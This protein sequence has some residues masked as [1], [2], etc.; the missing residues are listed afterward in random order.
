MFSCPKLRLLS[1]LLACILSSG[2]GALAAEIFSDSFDRPD[3]PVDGWTVFRGSWTL[4]DGELALTRPS[5]NEHWIWAGSPAL[6][7][8]ADAT[9]AIYSF[10]IRFLANGTNAQ[11]GRHGGFVFCADRPTQR[12]DAQFKG[13]FVDWID[14]TVDRGLRFTRVDSGQLVEIVRGAPDSPLE[15]PLRWRIEVDDTNI[16]LYGDD[17]LYIDV[18]DATYRGGY[19]GFWTW[20]GGQQIAYDDFT[21]SAEL[22]PLSACFGFSPE[23]PVSGTDMLFDAGCS[24]SEPPGSI[25]AYE[26]DF[27][28]GTTA[29]GAVV[30]HTYAFAD[31]YTVTLTI[32]N[33]AGASDSASRL[34]SV[35]GECLPFADDFERPPGP[36]DGWTAFQGDWNITASGQLSTLTAGQEHWVW[37]G[38]PPCLA[39]GNLTIEFDMEFV[40]RP[41]D[42]VGRHAGVFFFASEPRIRWGISGYDVWWID[43]TQDFGISIRRWD[44]GAFTFLTPGSFAAVPEPPLRWRVEVNGATIRVFGDGIQYVQLNDETYRQ[45]HLGFWAYSNTQDVLFDDLSV[46]SEPPRAVSACFEAPALGQAGATLRFDAS[47]STAPP[48]GEATYSWDFGDGQAGSGQI[49]EHA[50]G[51][52]GAYTVVLT[53]RDGAG[54]SDT[55]QKLVRVAE[56]LLPFA[57]CFDRDPGPAGGWTPFQ[58]DWLISEDERLATVTGGAEHWLWA[59]DPPRILSGDFT[60]EFEMEF[61]SHPGD[62]VGRHAGVF[63]YASAPTIRW[64]VSGYDV[65]WIDRGADFGISVRRWDSG[66]ITFLTPGTF[67]LV[68]EPPALWRVEVE[69]PAIRVYGDGV[70]YVE[71]EDDTYRAGYFG[72][73][74]YSNNQDVRFNDVLIGAA[75]LPSCGVVAAKRFVRGDADSDG[76]INLTDAVRVLNFL[77]TGGAPPACA[78]AADADDSGTLSITDAI[79]ILGWLFSGG[80]APMPPSPSTANYVMADCGGDPTADPLACDMPAAKCR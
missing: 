26:W 56:P 41:G 1:A 4:R 49:V 46:T 54:G 5:P 32:R 7:V 28:D 42:G 15:P 19:F 57:D 70:L 17:V 33:A 53:V 78:D 45:G 14:R 40:S 9:D 66:A 34:V 76:T 38:D 2:G 71:V 12:Y 29:N 59:G 60:L 58:G 31:N 50:Y 65:W 21:A 3:G 44:N 61:V 24:L 67:E 73:W 43:R 27:G 20:E 79:R 36:L 52:E 74:A 62:A 11:V 23:A 55:T 30:E 6:T 68:A 48:G 39:G 18:E 63:F 10:D 16:R 77:F 22:P 13:Y 72:L 64:Q 25:T 80:P 47:C 35:R 69:G 37:A 75:S 51:A 8:P